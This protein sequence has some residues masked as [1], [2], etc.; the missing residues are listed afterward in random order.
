MSRL[1]AT[2]F[3]ILVSQPLLIFPRQHEHTSAHLLIH[4]DPISPLP[5]PNSFSEILIVF[6]RPARKNTVAK[7]NNSLAYGYRPARCD[8]LLD[9]DSRFNGRRVTLTFADDGAAYASKGPANDP[10]FFDSFLPGFP[11]DVVVYD[12]QGRFLSYVAGTQVK[13]TAG[14]DG[15]LCLEDG[16]GGAELKTRW[17]GEVV[18]PP[19]RLEPGSERLD[20]YYHIN[21]EGGDSSHVY[22]NWV[23]RGEELR[24]H[25]PYC[26]VCAFNT[27]VVSCLSLLPQLRL[28]SRPGRLCLP[29]SPRLASWRSS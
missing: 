18:L 10:S 12:L 4:F 25:F 8:L 5:P 1:L 20:E 29:T 26:N 6:T 22:Y 2:L 17:R 27:S 7:A 16:L 11:S 21:S 23:E 9:L 19:R 3:I 24:R 13:W 15:D 14:L 28:S